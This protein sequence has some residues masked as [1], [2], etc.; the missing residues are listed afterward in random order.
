MVVDAYGGP[1]VRSRC[2]ISRMLSSAF[3]LPSFVPRTR[4]GSFLGS[5]DAIQRTF[6]TVARTC[7]FFGAEGSEVEFFSFGF[8]AALPLPVASFQPH[9]TMQGSRALVVGLGV[10]GTWH[11]HASPSCARHGPVAVRRSQPRFSRLQR[12]F[13]RHG[14]VSMRLSSLSLSA[15]RS[16]MAGVSPTWSTTLAAWGRGREKGRRKGGLDRTEG[17]MVPLGTR[18]ETETQR[19][20]GRE[21][22]LCLREVLHGIGKDFAD[23]WGGGEGEKEESEETRRGSAPRSAGMDRRGKRNEESH[24]NIKRTRRCGA[25]EK[26]PISSTP[27]STVRLQY[28]TRYHTKTEE[29][30]KRAE[31][32]GGGRTIRTQH[33][34]RRRDFLCENRTFSP[35]VPFL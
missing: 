30:K 32:R 22:T 19:R 15:T 24:R 9:A 14:D 33:G 26:C 13:P 16:V 7:E 31:E 1:V 21:R 3:L 6:R 4:V 20:E 8:D 35:T 29:G 23:G 2:S 5:G 18:G 28:Q 17:R 10:D 34:P 11:A 25:E 12:V 27:N